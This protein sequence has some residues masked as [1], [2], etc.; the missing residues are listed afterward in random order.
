MLTICITRR[1]TSVD[2]L[3]LFIGVMLSTTIYAQ[4]TPDALT[5]LKPCGLDSTQLPK[6]YMD[7]FSKIID[8]NANTNLGNYA[9]V[10]LKDPSATL[11]VTSNIRNKALLGVKLGGGA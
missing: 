10:D 11:G 8:P 2:L 5:G 7:Y 3:G 1:L 4:P 6:L 9:A